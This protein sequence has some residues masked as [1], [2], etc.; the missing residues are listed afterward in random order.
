MKPNAMAVGRL[1]IA[2]AVF[3]ATLSL[4]PSAS[5][6]PTRLCMFAKP[7]SGE[8]AITAIKNLE[9]KIGRSFDMRHGYYRWG[10]SFPG[11][12]ENEDEKVGRIPI[13]DWIARTSDG[14]WV[15]W[16]EIASGLHDSVIEARA[17]AIKAWG[18]TIYVSFH[19]EPEN[20]P[21]A[22]TPAEF[23][24]AFRHVRHVFEH[25]GAFNVRWLLILMSSTFDSGEADSFFAGAQYADYIG[26][27]GYNWYPGVPRASWRSFET[28]FRAAHDWARGVGKPLFIAEAGV[29]EDPDYPMRKANWFRDALTTLKSWGDVAAFCYFHSNKTYPFWVDSSK[30]ALDAYTEIARDPQLGGRASSEGTTAPAPPAFR[31]TNPTSP[32]NN[33]SPLVKGTAATGTT[34]RLHTD[35][36]CDSA[37]VATGSAASFASPGLAAAVGDDTSTTFY[38]TATDDTGAVSAC[39]SDSITYIEDS[40][41][42]PP[43]SAPDLAA[44]GDTGVSSADD[45]TNDTTPTFEG[46]AEPKTRVGIYVD[47]VRKGSATATSAGAYS[48]TTN[49]LAEGTH[50]IV[51]QA[52]DAAG[53]ASASSDAL[54]IT[55]DATPPGVTIDSKPTNPTADST[56][57]FAFSSP[58][59][60]TSFQCSLSSGA[61]DFSSCTSPA[62]YG[63]LADATYVF[64]VKAT[65]T[66][67]NLGSAS[68]T[69]ALD[70][71]P[72]PAPSAPDLAPGS[73]TGVSSADDLTN[74]TT[75]TFKGTAEADGTVEILVDGAAKGSGIAS[76]GSYSITT[77]AIAEG[78]HAITARLTD[79]AGNASSASDELAIVIDATAPVASATPA[80]GS[81]RS[82]QSVELSAVDSGGPPS[83]PAPA[84]HY[85]TDGSTPTAA[86]TAYSGRVT[87]ESNTTLKFIA[88]DA[89]GNGSAVSTETYQFE[90]SAADTVPPVAA[91]PKHSLV[92]NSRL[93]ST[94]VPVG[95]DWSGTDDGSGIAG[96]RLQQSVDGGQT[97]ADVA[98]RT[99]RTT[100]V[101]RMLAPGSK[102]YRFQVQATDGAGNS[103]AWA[104]GPPFQLRATQDTS[105]SISYTGT[106]TKDSLNSPFGGS[107]RYSTASGAKAT[108]RFTGSSFA[109]VTSKGPNRGIAEVWLDGVRVA[110]ADLY[111]ATVAPRRIAFTR[112]V[113]PTTAHTVEVRVTGKKNGSSKAT[114]IYID[115]FVT[116]V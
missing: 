114:R 2:V 104:A 92:L 39:S 52:N 59:T 93:S 35:A 18:N 116:I 95:V 30:A 55:I 86:S 94:S 54:G 20:D 38:A 84:I 23:A 47:G 85:T 112:T 5:A 6:A 28:I 72:P 71:A 24:A 89:A 19:H 107:S 105:T 25:R 102:S 14:T 70:A 16:K 99:P 109:W 75:P 82:P 27:D 40:T 45:I 61:L 46:T 29:M 15:P 9:S 4:A 108:F 44:G 58:D 110:T 74:D 90:T 103:S 98:L 68:Y 17:D 33:N 10:S 43:P 50:S 7:R 100:T 1:C 67:G 37:V 76:G 79:Q 11:A 12:P 41:S 111:A 13:V 83:A 34:V 49:G 62:G 78:T 22:G 97:Y 80:G 88:I 87:I 91:P 73:D 66:A 36:T 57:E 81:Y 31:G 42:P 53:N 77:T 64:Q 69:F 51:A 63:P 115:A 32:A 26:V 113:T 8:T 48:V 101:R 56:P 21:E 96:Y 60:Q 106:W 65:D 3:S